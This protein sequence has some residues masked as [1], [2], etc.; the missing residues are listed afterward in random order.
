MFQKILIANRGEI[1]IRIIRACKEMSISTVAV[2]SEADADS[3]HVRLADEAICVGQ[4][5]SILSYLNMASIITAA[6]VTDSEAIHPGYGFFA[7]NDHFAEICESCDIKFIGPPPSVIRN[8]GNKS[9]AKSL[10]IKEGI[11]VVPGSEG[12]IGTVDEAK[13]IADEIGYPVLIKAVAG[14]GGKGIREVHTALSFGN[15]YL[16][17][18]TEAEASFGNGEVYIEK[19]IQEPRHV[20]VQVLADSHGNVIHLGERD[21]TIQRRHQKLI[22]EAPSPVVDDKLRKKMGQDAI[23]LSR[24]SGYQNAGTVEFLVDKD[25][26]YHFI[27]M[28]T[29]IQVEHPVTEQ[30][31]G[32]D[33]IK[34]QIKIAYGSK[35]EFSQSDIKITGHAFEVRVNAEDWENDF[36]PSP[37][38]IPFCHLPG[39]RNIRVDSH[40]YSG[41]TIP[42]NYDSMVAKIIT[43]GKDRQEARKHMERALDEIVIDGVKTTIAFTR[44]IFHDSKFKSGYYSTQYIDKFTET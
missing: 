23:K 29:R 31:T 18:R 21:C 28:N 7:E 34:E 17:T 38:N 9:M 42:P 12:P 37:G 3:L 22:E 1:A 39:G 25:G 10:C 26:Q 36:R 44:R 14:G 13:L 33:L 24:S 20:E 4:A 30:V 8:L 15:A 2:Y 27:E 35:L 43:W 32:I 5:S 19:L 16:T 41:Y 6:E 11:P 40:L